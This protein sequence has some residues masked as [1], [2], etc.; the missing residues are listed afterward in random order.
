MCGI[1]GLYRKKIS[2]FDI[3]ELELC[4]KKMTYRGP[5]ANCFKVFQNLILGHRRLSIID[6]NSTSNQPM[7]S[8][9]ERYWLT[10]NGEIYNYIELRLV[11][12]NDGVKFKTDSDTEVLLH[13]LICYGVKG[14]EKL[15][16][17]FAFAFYD[18]HKEELLLARDPF[19]IKPLFYTERNDFFSFS[20][21]IRALP[22]G[23]VHKTQNYNTVYKY[24]VFGEYDIGDDT[25]IDGVKSL[26][27]GSYIKF[28]LTSTQFTKRKWWN[29]QLLPLI[30]VSVEEASDKLRDLL[31]ASIK[32]QMRSDVP[33]ALALSGGIDSSILVSGVRSLFP[34]SNIMT[35]SYVADDKKL[36]EEKWMDIVVDQTGVKS[37]KIRIDQNEF[38][39]D[40]MKLIEIQGEP[41][42]SS[43]IYAQYKLFQGISQHGIKVM[44]DGQG[45]DEMFAGY[46]GYPGQAFKSVMENDGIGAAISYAMAWV[47]NSGSPS[48]FIKRSVSEYSSKSMSD[49]F[50]R[51]N[52]SKLNPSWLKKN[53]LKEHVIN[54]TFPYLEKNSNE[55]G[56]R[57]AARL[58]HSFS[59]NGLSA[60][61][62]HAD[63]NSMSV[64]IENRVP[65]LD[66]DIFNFMFSLPDDFM[67]SKHSAQ[68]KMLLRKSMEGIAPEP[69]LKRTDKIGFATPESSLLLK[70]FKFVEQIL[71]QS[72]N[73]DVLDRDIIFSKFKLM[74]EEKIVRDWTLWRWINYISWSQTL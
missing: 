11:L 39:N 67:I 14:L 74:K 52:G 7:G 47:K 70:N 3:S 28:D 4:L 22:M 69:I 18:R 40:F 27:A 57:V 68:S 53:F 9:D 65:F 41:F 54:P 20:S 44:I 2:D 42:G 26:E 24:L 63:R 33:L 48:D 25:F 36:S 72:I 35:F 23:G 17:M 45:A 30:N 49:L 58:L 60:L 12:K 1:V 46:S 10:F 50:M 64:S 31:L 51:L 38:K 62:R 15:N 61:L 5:D 16:G 6:L 8:E 37:H 43:S 19:G 71:D 66:T 13:W 56:R 34:D 59:G 73:S 21:D 29:P 55:R 32:R